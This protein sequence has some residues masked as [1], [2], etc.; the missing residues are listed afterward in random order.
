MEPYCPVTK[1][2]FS[3]KKIFID[4]ESGVITFGIFFCD[5]DDIVVMVILMSQM[6]ILTL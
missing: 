1:F 3:E 2:H 5:H 6:I 4:K